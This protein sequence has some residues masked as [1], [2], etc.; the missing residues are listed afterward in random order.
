MPADLLE[1]WVIAGKNTRKLRSSIPDRTQALA[2]DGVAVL[3]IPD[4]I[5]G[6]FF[7]RNTWE[8]L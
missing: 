7:D 4:H 8:L 1:S 6:A 2:Q 3:L 5:G